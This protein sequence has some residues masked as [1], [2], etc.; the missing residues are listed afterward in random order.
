VRF[1]APTS[2]AVPE[3]EGRRLLVFLLVLS[4]VSW[5][6]TW[7]SGKLI[8]GLASP[9]ATVFYRFLLTTASLLLVCLVRRERL[10]LPLRALP[11]VL[12]ASI[13]MTAYNHFFFAGLRWGLANKGGV[14]VTCLNPV[15][16]FLGLH[17]IPGNAARMRRKKYSS[18]RNP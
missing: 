12:A 4:M 7:P 9:E 18:S 13:L 10:R 8:S 2:A 11:G 1:S 17:R 16:T 14:I 15:F 6:G 3:Q 5:G